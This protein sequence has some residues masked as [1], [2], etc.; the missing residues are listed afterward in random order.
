MRGW[1]IPRYFGRHEKA[2]PAEDATGYQYSP[3]INGN[4][5]NYPVMAVCDPAQARLT[6]DQ[7]PQ[8]RFWLDDPKPTAAE[9]LRRWIHG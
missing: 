3:V 1:Q 6:W 9:R 5:W 8:V 7:S 4:G 2:Y